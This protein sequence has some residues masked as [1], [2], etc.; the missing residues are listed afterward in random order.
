MRILITGSSGLLG[1][2][3]ALELGA[4]HQIIGADRN[5]LQ[6]PPF[7][8]AVADLLAADAIPALL[9]ETEPHAVIH[10][11]A[12][13][14]V[15]AC[16][17]DPEMAACLNAAL[18]GEIAVQC[19]RRGIGLVHIST[20][21][22]FDGE[23]GGYTEEDQ[24]NPLNVYARTKLDG[25]RAVLEAMPQAVVARINIFGWSASGSR[26]LAEFFYYGLRDSEPRKGFMDVYFCPVLV[27]HLAGVFEDMLQRRLSGL[28]HLVSPACLTKY[29]F[30]VQIAERFGFDPT[31]IEPVSVADF[32]L[33]AARSPRLMLDTG[34]LQRDLGRTLPDVYAGLDR[35]H[36]LFTQS[37]PQ[38]L[39]GMLA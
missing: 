39:S 36:E 25:E 34:K 16:E 3:L 18:P 12:M 37:Y 11:A 4:A 28:Y 6:S 14:N 26:S 27:N 8:V 17:S 23:T 5:P 1:L 30:G 24:P 15:D 22:V 31:A 29:E 7:E 33:Q 20:D 19:A 13:A 32:G 38:R 35:F 10:C 9:D 21:G 2:N